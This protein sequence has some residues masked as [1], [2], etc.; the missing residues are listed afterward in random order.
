MFTSPSSTSVTERSSVRLSTPQPM[1]ALP[2]GS[3]SINSTR[4]CVAASED[5]RLT[6]VV[7]FPT[8]PFWFATAMIR[9]TTSNPSKFDE[10][11]LG[12]ESWDGDRMHREQLP[13]RRKRLDFV[14]RHSTFHGEEP[15]TP[16]GQVSRHPHELRERAERAG[17]HA[18]EGPWRLV[19]LRPERDHFDVGQVE[20]RHDVAQESGFFSG[21]FDEGEAPVGVRDGERQ[22]R[23]ARAGADVR[24]REPLQE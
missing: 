5:A 9:F 4:R 6:A 10:T 11:T 23:K 18:V 21:G 17:D 8:P 3:R 16:S 7:V 20:A 13:A 1:V 12:I 19:G 2:C 24:D 15:P 14:L 22:A